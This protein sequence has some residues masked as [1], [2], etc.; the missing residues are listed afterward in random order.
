MTTFA[1]LG[2]S[3]DLVGRLS[4]LAIEQPTPVQA[5]AIPP[6]Q[7]RSDLVVQAPTGSGKTHAFL[8]PAIELLRSGAGLGT[9]VLVVTPTRELALQVE[10]VFRSLETGIPCTVLY[11]GVGYHSQDRA[12]ADGAQVVV[13]TPGRILDMVERRKLS[14]ARVEYLVLDE[15]DEML[16]IGFAPQVEKILGLTWHP[17]TVLASATMPEW[18]RKVVHDYLHDPV[19]I[20]VAALPQDATLEHARVLVDQRQRVDALIAALRLTPG[21][22]IVFGRTKSGVAELCRELNRRRVRCSQLQGDMRQIERDRVMASFREGA[23]RVLVATNVAARGLDVSQVDLVVNYELPESPEALTHRIGR[24]ARAGR[25]GRAL[26][27]TSHG[28]GERWRRL[29]A[30]GAPELPLLDLEK[31][32]SGEWSYAGTQAATQAASP[33]PDVAAPRPSRE[34]GARPRRRRRAR[35]ERAA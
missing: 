30:Q 21:S 12:L 13:G 6:L 18:V 33:S 7:E 22:A 27:I 9:R 31:L 8:L 20:Q 19:Q 24:T 35:R 25:E 10:S 11:G 28:D 15:A 2:V 23:V 16:D 17:Q 1:D 5:A 4:E 34:A 14:L 29:R 3:P 26:T 32:L